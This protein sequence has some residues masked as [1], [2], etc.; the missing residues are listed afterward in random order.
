MLH[1]TP[2]E[3]GAMRRSNPSDIAFLESHIIWEAEQQNKHNKELE[4]KMK[5]SKSRS[6]R[7]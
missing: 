2:S 5:A 4:K 1:K 7:R 3:I 6:R